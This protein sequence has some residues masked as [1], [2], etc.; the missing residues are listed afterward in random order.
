MANQED[1]V[2]E[3]R[4]QKC[5]FRGKPSRS[6]MSQKCQGREGQKS[7]HRIPQRIVFGEDEL[8][9]VKDWE[10]VKSTRQT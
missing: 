2:P 3:R 8:L 4:Q 7:A 5:V 1:R 10:K 9:N 6:Q